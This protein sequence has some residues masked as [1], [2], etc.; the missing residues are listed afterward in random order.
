VHRI[1]VFKEMIE[2]VD[3]KTPLYNVIMMA[4]LSYQ[5]SAYYV[6]QGQIEDARYFNA[7]AREL[8]PWREE[9]YVQ[10]SDIAVRERKFDD[11]RSM[12]NTCMTAISKNGDLCKS[13]LFLVP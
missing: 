12:L 10:S 11:A 13:A 9:Y 2:H 4:E 1:L 3:M 6:N 5:I 7:K 8:Y